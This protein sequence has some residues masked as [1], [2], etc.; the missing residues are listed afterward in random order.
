[1]ILE[2]LK[3]KLHRATVTDANLEYEGSITIDADLM[4]QA[5]ILPFEKVA[6]YNL[7]NGS[8]FET[9]AIEGDRK[10]GIV[11][12]NGAAA[13]LTSPGDRVIIVAY[14]Q[15]EAAEAPSHLP[16]VLLLDGD[17]KVIARNGRPL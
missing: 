14:C 7:T 12:I 8:R 1:M 17:N 3:C 13:H 16:I 11:C 10:S 2:M 5:G 6:V 15:L 4:E 9:Y